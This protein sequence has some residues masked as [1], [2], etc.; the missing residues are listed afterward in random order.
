MLYMTY[1]E[2]FNRIVIKGGQIMKKCLFHLYQI[3]TSSYD[4]FAMELLGRISIHII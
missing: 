4:R 2:H 1:V 3:N